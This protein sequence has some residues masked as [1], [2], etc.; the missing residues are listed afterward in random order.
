LA[1][2]II[3]VF[4]SFDSSTQDE[5]KDTMIEHFY[6][7]PHSAQR[8]RSGPL[9][10]HL[11]DF[12]GL[13]AEQGYSRQAARQKLRLAADLSRW[14]ERKGLPVEE[15][16]EE[17]VGDFFSARWRR[18]RWHNSDQ[19][20]LSMLLR[21]LRRANVIPESVIP[22]SQTPLDRVEQ[23]YA[24]FLTQERGLL[25]TTLDSYLPVA[26]H[27]LVGRFGSGKLR[28]KAL[29]SHD[30][31]EFILRDLA[32]YS[33]KRV[34]LAT[35]A[36]RS[37]LGHLYQT[38]QLAINLA[39]AVP[40]VAGRHH[41]GLP[42]FLEPEQVE[43]L[44]NHCDRGCPTGQRDYA[45]LLLLARLGL[46]AGEVVQLSLEDINW[47]AGE[48]L[49]RGKSAR[50]DQLP[51][52][53]DVGRALACYL[54]WGRPQCS[55]RRVFIRTK[56]PRQGFSGSAAVDGIVDRALSRA[57]LDPAQRGA[58]LLRHSLATRMLRGGA[59]LTQIGQILRHQLPQT[60][61]IYAKVDLRAL[62]NLAQ[63]WPGGA[64]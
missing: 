36:L 4:F 57:Q 51:L 62:R 10:P 59:S 40:T 23:D 9:E 53:S 8:L 60:T 28:L 7:Q 54:K 58:H 34:Q 21:Q 13:L 42:R 43:R 24:R 35:S 14:L 52:P 15:L 56:A 45:V 44:L 22:A 41:C 5:G 25:P 37:F 50:I 33:L 6:S 46:R 64:R 48:L 27:F 17:R 18:R 12:A 55:S 32:A 63:P 29:R 49:I 19:S 31:S 39:A 26:R 11:D 3:R 1:L 61:E 2:G 16:D 30:V 47:E 38:G 20:S